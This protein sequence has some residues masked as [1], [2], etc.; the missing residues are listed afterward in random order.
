MHKALGTEGSEAILVEAYTARIL[1]MT[2]KGLTAEAE[3]LLGLVRERYHLPDQWLAEIRTASAARHG[4]GDAFLAPLNDPFAPPE[5]Q[6]AILNKIKEQVVDLNVLTAS[7]ALPS[8][9]P[10]KVQAAAVLEAFKS[11]TSGPVSEEAIALPEVPRRSPLAPWK[12][13]IKALFCFYRREDDL[14][15]KHLQSV[16]AHSAPARLVPVIRA[17]LLGKPGANL[18]ESAQALVGQ[19]T[20]N[21]GEIRKSLQNLETALKEDRPQPILSAIRNAV[22]VCERYAPELLDRLRQHISIRSWILGLDDKAVKKALGGPSLKNA[23]FW[24]LHARAAESKGEVFVA[25][26]MWDEF[27]KHAVHEGI[28]ANKTQ[29]ESVVY[30]HMA[31]LLSDRA[32]VDFEWKRANFENKF[33]RS[34]GFSSYYREQPKSVTEAVRGTHAACRS[35]DFLYPH[36]LYQM[37]CDIAP[38]PEGF[39]DWLEWIKRGPFSQKAIDQ[40]AVTWHASIPGDVRP[41]IHL[42]RSAEERSAFKMC[43]G[44]LEQAEQIDALNQDVRKMRRK[45][46]VGTVL[47]HLKQRKPHLVRKDLDEMKRLP[48]FQEG[49]RPAFLT[50]LELVCRWIQTDESELVELSSELKTLLGGELPAAMMLTAIL[51]SCGMPEEMS[52]LDLIDIHGG[53]DADL[54]E[55]IARVCLLGDDVGTP[56]K[57]PLRREKSL[58][59]AFKSNPPS[60]AAPLLKAIGEAALRGR[61]FQLAYAISGAGLRGSDAASARFLLLRAQS[62][63]HWK[64][65]RREKCIDAAIGLARRD[66]DMDLLHE[67]VELRQGRDGTAAASPFFW[68][69]RMDRRDLSI[70]ANEIEAILKEEKE[71]FCYP[72]M[73]SFFDAP[74]E[75]D[76]EWE[77]DDDDEWEED[78]DEWDDDES[79]WE[80]DAAE[81]ESMLEGDFPDFLQ[82]IPPKA[83]PLLLEIAVKYGNKRAGFPS[84]EELFKKEPELAN[85]L[86]TILGEA[87]RKGHFKNYG[88]WGSGSGGPGKGKKGSKK[89]GRR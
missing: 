20:G 51:K 37:A 14:C 30:L 13:V 40:V 82:D 25:C 2:E 88:D 85:K 75:D 71:A 73:D 35:L 22:F 83:L 65:R 23:Y 34:D 29:E 60:L 27:I 53:A 10:M 70:N 4:I 1:Q 17:M 74:D 28:F 69:G 47:R 52:G 89:K 54:D 6:T 63:P 45:V 61:F 5:A 68:S 84:P 81:L 59:E 76:E 57:I 26:A 66:R 87:E 44:Y 77:D 58:E 48:L 31:N 19:V 46:L 8:D 18:P 78:T 15:E 32:E 62:L 64:A 33:N 79:D 50:A 49:D 38:T 72:P 12:I 24:R 86:F 56:V 43:L 11:V 7:A 80:G 3:A 21:P 41:L 42:A 16:E 9:H 67:A 55:G 39:E 36:R